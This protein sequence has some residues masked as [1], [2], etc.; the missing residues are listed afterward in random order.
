MRK[1]ERLRALSGSW[2]LLSGAPGGV[3]GAIT[4][5]GVLKGWKLLKLREALT[6]LF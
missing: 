5:F 1:F 2:A 4:R 6:V 3:G